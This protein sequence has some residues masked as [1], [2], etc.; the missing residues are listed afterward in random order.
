MDSNT[1]NDDA[2]RHVVN[3]VLEAV[4]RISTDDAAAVFTLNI[5]LSGVPASRLLDILAS[6]SSW[7]LATALMRQAAGFPVSQGG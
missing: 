2:C 6:T 1:D 3:E 5:W 4:H 7:G